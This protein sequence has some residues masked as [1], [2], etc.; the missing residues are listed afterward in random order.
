MMRAMLG[1]VAALA[2]SACASTTEP[3]PA[4]ISPRPEAAP[5]RP[6]A[7]VAAPTPGDV[8]V[9]ITAVQAGQTVHVRVNHRFSVELIGVPTAGYVWT[10]VQMPA[11]LSRAGETGG[12]TSAAQSQPGFVGGNHWEVFMFVPMEAGTGEIVFAQRRPWETNEPPADTFRVSVIA[13]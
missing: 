3:A 8:S 12:N 13:E 2:L 7:E 9:R 11:F 10:P 5:V 1:C 4:V 6:N